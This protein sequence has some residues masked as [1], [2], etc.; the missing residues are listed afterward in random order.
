[1]EIDIQQFAETPFTRASSLAISRSFILFGLNPSLHSQ[2]PSSA[3]QPWERH[4]E[5]IETVKC[6]YEAARGEELTSVLSLWLLP[7]APSY[8]A[9]FGEVNLQR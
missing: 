1:M 8:A 9:V 3:F 2:A 7:S 4:V 6:S 5:G